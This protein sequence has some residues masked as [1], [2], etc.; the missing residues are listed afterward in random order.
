M[1]PQ[2]LPLWHIRFLSWLFFF[3]NIYLLERER[4]GWSSHEQWGEGENLKESTEPD[5]GLDL[6]TLETM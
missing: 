6:T 1:L 5:V 4:E 2:S 3:I